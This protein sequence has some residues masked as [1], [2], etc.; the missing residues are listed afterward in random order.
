MNAFRTSLLGIVLCSL[1][2][3][4]SWGA[5]PIVVRD[6]TVKLIEQRDVPA[7]ETG[8]LME[9]SVREG[10]PVQRGQMVGKMDDRQVLLEQ[11]LANTQLAISKQ[12]SDGFLAAELAEKDFAR[13]QELLLQ[14][15]LLADIAHRKAKN[16]VRVLAAQ[17]A[18]AVAKN[19]W[20]RATKARAEFADSVS[21]SELEGLELAHQRMELESQQAEFEREIDA[22]TAAGEDRE[23]RIQG[24]G[25][26]QSRISVNQSA[27]DKV[28]AQ[29]QAT[30][31]LQT[32]KLA[33]LAVRRH[34]VISPIDG[35]VVERYKQPG[36]WV[37]LGEP[38]VRVVQLTRLRAEGYLLAPLAQ[39]LRAEPNVHLVTQANEGETLTREGKVVFIS[40]EVDT[41]NNE[42]AF[43]V[44]FDNADESILPG[45][46]MT[47]TTEQ[48]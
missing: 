13:Q 5:D 41:V 16:R 28:V 37:K 39:R 35:I 32:A 3:G 34:Q 14:Q 40:P 12:R 33:E 43:L 48:P 22:L 9:L 30:A 24:I 7:R 38:I 45:M 21:Q 11:E 19:E 10:S 26:E 8:L 46:Q 18:E 23:L 20:L 2:Y 29:L 31:S 47:M 42:V 25:L 1:A 44:E 17:K 27:I 4:S 15:Q 6:L 36:E